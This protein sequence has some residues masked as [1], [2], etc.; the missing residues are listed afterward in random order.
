MVNRPHAG[1]SVCGRFFLVNTYSSMREKV[2]HALS[3][4]LRGHL[5]T[6]PHVVYYMACCHERIGTHGTQPAESSLRT[7][8]CVAGRK[9]GYENRISRRSGRVVGRHLS[10]T[11]PSRAVAW[12]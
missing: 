1:A 12:Q 4:S 7:S 2:E 11:T 6:R 8:G 5:L 3:F 10:R 9:S